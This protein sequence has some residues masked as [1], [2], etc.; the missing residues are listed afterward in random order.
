[1]KSKS[2]YVLQ[3]GDLSKIDNQFHFYDI[4]IFSSRKKIEYAIQSRIEINK[5]INVIYDEGYCGIGTR[6]N[7]LITYDCLSTDGNQMKVR[8]Q[9]L[10]KK[11][12]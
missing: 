2:I 9:L 11:L 10:E 3:T 4:E 12:N 1:M 5:G 7:T 8:Y 6:K